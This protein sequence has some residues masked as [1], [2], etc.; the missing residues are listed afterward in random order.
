MKTVLEFEGER[1]TLLPL[2]GQTWIICG[3]RKFDQASLFDSAMGTVTELRGLPDRVIHG[4]ATGADTLA[5]KWATKMGLSVV[6]V[7][8]DWMNNGHAAG[9]IRNQKMLDL[10]KPSVVV[11]FPGGA[12]TADMVAKARVAKVDVIEIQPHAR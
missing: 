3:G 9:P 5:D 2:N 6:K 11:A 12:G 8:A 7:M 10:Y 4:G 1:L